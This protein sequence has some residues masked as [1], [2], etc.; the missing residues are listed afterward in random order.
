MRVGYSAQATASVCRK[1]ERLRRRAVWHAAALGTAAAVE[2][3]GRLDVLVDSDG[4]LQRKPALKTHVE[5]SGRRQ[6][7]ATPERLFEAHGFNAFAVVEGQGT[8]RAW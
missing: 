5:P 6:R 2:A 7:L 3:F 1:V 4:L 8:L